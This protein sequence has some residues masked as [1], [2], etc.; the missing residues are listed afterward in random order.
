VTSLAISDAD[1]KLLW[2]RSGDC[3]AFPG[4]HQNLTL[5]PAAEGAA[6]GS[7]KPVVVGEEAHIVAEED[8][9]PRGN[10]AMPISERNAYPNRVLLC[11][12]HHRLIDKDHGVHFSVAQLRQ[13]KADHETWVRRTLS[14]SQTEAETHARQRQELLLEGAS[15]SRGRLVARWVAAGVSPELAQS[16]ADDDRVGAPERLGRALPATGLAVLT[17]DF[18]SGKSVTGERIYLA[19]NAAATAD[20]TAPLPAYL[21][22][23]SVSGPL[24]DTV[25]AA[26]D[27]LGNPAE[28]GLSLIL[29]GLDE[30]GQARAAELLDEARALVCTWPRTRAVITARPGLPLQRDEFRLAYPPLSD[31]EAARLAETLAGHHNVLLGQSEPIR[32]MLHLPLFLI[33]AAL[34][35]QAGAEV[36]QSRGT[37]LRALVDAPLDRNRRPTERSQA[38]L[39]SLARLTVDSGGPVAAAELGDNATCKVLETRLV[40]RESGLLRFA[41]PVVEQ[42]FAAQPLLEYGLTEFDLEDLASLDRWRDTLTLAVTIGSWQQVSR[43]LDS[44]AA[45]QP[46]A[47]AWVVASAVPPPTS[48]PSTGLPGDIECARRIHQALQA[49]VDALAPAGRHLRLTD[50]KGQVRTVGAGRNGEVAAALCLGDNDGVDAVRLPRLDLFTGTAADGSRWDL[51]RAAHVPGEYLAWPWQW[52]L[53]WVTTTLEP[54][55]R[56]KAFPLPDSAPYQDERRWQLAKALTGRSGNLLHAPIDGSSLRRIA[57]EVLA[58]LDERGIPLY[59]VLRSGRPITAFGRDELA[60]LIAELEGDHTVLAGD[61]KL[62]RPYPVPDRQSGGLVRELYSDEALRLL[63]EQVHTSALGIYRDL[64]DVWFPKLAPTLGLASFM[65]ILIRGQLLASAHSEDY[66]QPHFRYQMTPLPLPEAPRA[67]VKLVTEPAAFREFDLQ[68]ARAQFLRLRD[69]IARLHPGAEGWVAPQAAR[70]T[71]SF[72]NDTPATSLAYQWL[73]EDLRRLRVVRQNLP[74]GDD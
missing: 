36:P 1:R 68:Q 51:F 29:D 41:L 66:S 49:W 74:M 17:G 28:R 12:T 23:K 69:E 9:G 3:C 65:P 27:R 47:A 2:G 4:C 10:P 18:G 24:L 61:G 30:P 14:G 34:R 5:V 44:L 48:E 19:D 56:A 43:L 50:G 25:R 31:E 32:Q 54:T 20:D 52:G 55:L 70:T 63:I 6:S 59:H 57:A 73:W 58:Q 46:G 11:G 38:G 39:E 62:H 45:R 60:R 72:W 64:V 21:I 8:N 26:V 35:Q 33:V 40:V 7:K 16:L 13:L 42:Y 71:G 37:F 53:D 15:A 22:A 67:E